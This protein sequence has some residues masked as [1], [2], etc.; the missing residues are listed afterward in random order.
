MSLKVLNTK[1]TAFC[2][3]TPCGL[4]ISVT[5]HLALDPKYLVLMMYVYML[6]ITKDNLMG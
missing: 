1:I 3:V 5:K 6:K 4:T 2:D